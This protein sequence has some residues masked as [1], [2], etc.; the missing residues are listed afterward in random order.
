MVLACAG[1]FTDA[2]TSGAEG[3]T[4]GGCPV[5]SRGCPCTAGRGCDDGLDCLLPAEM[6]AVPGCTPGEGLCSCEGMMCEDGFVCV[7]AYCEPVSV[8]GTS[9]DPMPGTS[10]ADTVPPE[11]SDTF[12]GTTFTSIG[13]EVGPMT[14][15][16]GTS[17]M[18]TGMGTMGETCA[19][20]LEDAR[21]GGCAG[22]WATCDSSC[23]ALFTCFA[24][25]KSPS[26]CEDH[27]PFDLSW[28]DF[29]GCAAPCEALCGS[30][31][32][33]PV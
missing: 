7:N 1:C 31:L 8:G 23:E 10:T 3:S 32:Y 25:Q 13:S 30:E 12:G 4:G 5:G 29:A 26:C 9:M 17:L 21:M 2:P 22:E 6:C 33:C 19:T 20:C 15:S 27:S 18:T 11:S 14:S 16:P 24:T 28:N